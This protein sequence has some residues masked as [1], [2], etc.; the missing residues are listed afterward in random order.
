MRYDEMKSS[1]IISRQSITIKQGKD[2]DLGSNKSSID[3]SKESELSQ[4]G[5]QEKKS[6]SGAVIKSILKNTGRSFAQ[7]DQI[8]QSQS[9]IKSNQIFP[10]D[11]LHSQTDFSDVSRLNSFSMKKLLQTESTLKDNELSKSNYKYD[12]YAYPANLRIAYLHG[13]TK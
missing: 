9:K 10:L 13:V 11:S 2:D 1:K 6:R 3:E 5:E 8:S 4:S 12:E 7:K